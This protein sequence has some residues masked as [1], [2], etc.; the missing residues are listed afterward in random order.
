MTFIVCIDILIHDCTGGK[1]IWSKPFPDEFKPN[2]I[3]SGS[4]F[5]NAY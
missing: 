5:I 4:A 2:L 3:H 1:S